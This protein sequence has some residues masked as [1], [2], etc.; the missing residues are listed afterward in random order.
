MDEIA[1]VFEELELAVLDE[2][3]LPGL[4]DE[5]LPELEE[6]ELAFEVAELPAL[7]KLVETDEA[8]LDELAVL[9]ELCVQLPVPDTLF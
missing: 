5:A 7:D 9:D 4:D 1:P 3:E 2:D 8:L 6:E